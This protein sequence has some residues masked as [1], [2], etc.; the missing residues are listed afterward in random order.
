MSFDPA[1]NCFLA[2]ETS[3]GVG[4]AGTIVV[5]GAAAS[6]F[7]AAGA[8]A[9]VLAVVAGDGAAGS[10]ANKSAEKALAKRIPAAILIGDEIL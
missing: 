5:L 3:A 9:F 10:C 1:A 7:D 2:A 4:G 6:G 8:K